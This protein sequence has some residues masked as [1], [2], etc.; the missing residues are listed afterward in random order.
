[1]P[2][3]SFKPDTTTGCPGQVVCF[4]NN[5]TTVGAATY[6]WNFGDG[7]TSG[8]Q[9]PCHTYTAS[10]TYTVNLD[11]TS[12]H[13]STDSNSVNL[14]TII[15]GPIA[16]FTPSATVIQQPQSEIDFTNQSTNALTYLWNFG[17][18]GNSTDI[19]PVFNFTNYGRYTVVLNAYN[20]LGCVD[21]TEIPISV[22]PPQ[23]FFIPNVFTPNNDGNNDNFYIE[24]QEGV[25]VIEFTIFDRWGEKVHDGQYP[26]DGTYKGKPCPE[27]VY[28][29][30]FKL[31]LAANAI[32]I[33]RT[34]SVTLMR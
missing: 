18:V 2:V 22:L 14:I 1:M 5:S 21:S 4:T 25:T 7:T 16:K 17:G 27:G 32:G 9:S 20:A 24:L 29:Y 34:G 3:V 26:W 6:L 23:N 12:Q 28:V 15:P 11:V 19:N 31:Q 33:K 8:A 30:V 10:G 13:C